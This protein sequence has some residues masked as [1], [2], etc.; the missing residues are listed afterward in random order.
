MY[1][2][3]WG[4]DCSKAKRCSLMQTSIFSI[5]NLDLYQKNLVFVW[6]LEVKATKCFSV[7]FSASGWVSLCLYRGYWTR[8]LHTAGT[9]KAKRTYAINKPC[10]IIRDRNSTFLWCR[11]MEW[12][13]WRHLTCSVSQH[14]CVLTCSASAYVA[15]E[16]IFTPTMVLGVISDI[17]SSSSHTPARKLQT[18]SLLAL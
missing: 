13:F 1:W 9:R 16:R 8:S 11:H 17:C 2:E 10:W 3:I 6:R 15:V 5:F 12:L 4:E 18:H 7:P 14:C